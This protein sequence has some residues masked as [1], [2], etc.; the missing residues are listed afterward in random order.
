MVS[1][2]NKPSVTPID[3]TLILSS[4]IFPFFAAGG[5]DVD[6]IGS[7]SVGGAGS[8]KVKQHGPAGV[9]GKK[10]AGKSAQAGAPEEKDPDGSIRVPGYRGVW[11]NQ[12]GQHFVKIHGERLSEEDSSDTLYFDSVDEAAKKHDSVLKEKDPGGKGEF[13]FKAD[14]S[15]IVYEDVTISS[16]TGLGGSA[17]SVVPALSVVNIKVCCKQGTHEWIEM[18][19]P[20]NVLIRDSRIYHET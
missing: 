9:V 3:Q 20:S 14:G 10:K 16:T 12:A 17:A 13:N 18:T 1:V 6:G 11:V 4:S 2:E 15:K 8:I 7:P 19:L 5:T